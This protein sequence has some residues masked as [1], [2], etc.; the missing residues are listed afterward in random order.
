MC[1]AERNTV[2]LLQGVLEELCDSAVARTG[3]VERTADELRHWCKV[4]AQVLPANGQ[5]RLAISQLALTKSITETRTVVLE[6][7]RFV[8][9]FLKPWNQ[10]MS[11]ISHVRSTP[12][13]CIT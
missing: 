6:L 11:I 10:K 4:A 3:D 12:F 5:A 8:N 1:V 9:L 2:V 7:I 13:L